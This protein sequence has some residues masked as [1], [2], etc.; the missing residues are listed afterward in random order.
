MK[1]RKEK[2]PKTVI[3]MKKDICVFV[4]FC[5]FQSTQHSFFLFL[6]LILLVPNHTQMPRQMKREGR[7]GRKR[8][9]KGREGEASMNRASW[10]MDKGCVCARLCACA[11]LCWL[12]MS[13]GETWEASCLCRSAKQKEPSPHTPT[14]YISQ[15]CVSFHVEYPSFTLIHSCSHHHH[16]WCALKRW[17]KK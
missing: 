11:G 17:K 4:L 3:G 15:L 12:E 14:F 2:T 8:R 13:C 9:E 1:W 5:F 10:V 6:L 7:W 16:C